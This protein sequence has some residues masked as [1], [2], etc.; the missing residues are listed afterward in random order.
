MSPPVGC[1]KRRYPNQGD[2]QVKFWGKVE[3]ITVF[4][5]SLSQDGITLKSSV[6]SDKCKNDW[7]FLTQQL[8]LVTEVTSL[9]VQGIVGIC[10]ISIKC[11]PFSISVKMALCTTCN[12]AV[13]YD[14]GQDALI[15]MTTCLVSHDLLCS[16]LHSFLNGRYVQHVMQCT[17]WNTIYKSNSFPTYAFHKVLLAKHEDSDDIS[18]SSLFPYY[19]FHASWYYF[20]E[21][22]DID[23]EEAFRCPL[24]S[25][26]PTTVIC[27]AKSL[28]FRRD[29]LL[30]IQLDE[31][32]TSSDNILNG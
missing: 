8:P 24:C 6:E 9:H 28:A 19:V 18:F 13:P 4:F 2:I 22:L 5:R 3:F 25:E 26:E 30:H 29:L 27:D 32:E 23:Y 11:L 20:L 17:K 21:L 7:T 10:T 1:Q 14:G 31:D 16:Y 12:Q 15:N